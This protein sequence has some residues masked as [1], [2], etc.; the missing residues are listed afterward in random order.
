MDRG[1][2]IYKHC[3]CRIYVL[4]LIILCEMP[5]VLKLTETLIYSHKITSIYA[6]CVSKQDFFQCTLLTYS[7][8]PLQT[9]THCRNCYIYFIYKFV[10]FKKNIMCLDPFGS[11][12][13]SWPLRDFSWH[14]FTHF[15]SHECLAALIGKVL[16]TLS[17]ISR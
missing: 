14:N 4:L 12:K 13:H 5:V 1:F 7:H 6:Y 11:N 15:L 16:W 9:H 10:G 3:Y 8:S 2:I 17:S